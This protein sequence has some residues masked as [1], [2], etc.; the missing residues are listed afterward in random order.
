MR[1]TPTL[2]SLF[3]F[4]REGSAL[5]RKRYLLPGAVAILAGLWLLGFVMF[6]ADTTTSVGTPVAVS[7]EGGVV[8]F[9]GVGGNRVWIGMDALT[10]GAGTRLLISGVNPEVDRAGIRELI[11]DPDELF[12]CCVDLDY[13]ARNTW[14]NARETAAWAERYNFT[15]IT[16]VTALFHEKRSLALLHY[17]MPDAEIIS[18]HRTALGAGRGEIDPWSL[19]TLRILAWEYTKYETALARIRFAHLTGWEF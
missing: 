2:R 4:R 1:L 19:N 3:S 18:Y 10:R 17:Y 11:D 14:E 15:T 12:E 6:V 7:S 16:L 9:T 13:A 5:P 8:V